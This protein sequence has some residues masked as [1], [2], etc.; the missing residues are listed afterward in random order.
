MTDDRIA[1]AEIPEIR[2]MGL[3]CAL[4][5]FLGGL[6]FI[7]IV[8]LATLL[9]PR[10]DLG[11]QGA[12]VAKLLLGL[13]SGKGVSSGQ[14]PGL[15]VGVSVALDSWKVDEVIGLGHVAEGDSS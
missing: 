11:E 2:T 13:L 8:T 6:F 12:E 10:V 4:L 9:E 7:D 14:K 1:L 3:G 5:H 15:Q